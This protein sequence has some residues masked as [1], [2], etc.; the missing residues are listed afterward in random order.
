MKDCRDSKVYWGGG[1]KDRDN[2]KEDGN[3]WN[4]LESYWDAGK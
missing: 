3:Y 2:G 4:V 1:K